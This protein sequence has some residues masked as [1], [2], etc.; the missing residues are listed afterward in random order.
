MRDKL[1]YS[2]GLKEEARLTWERISQGSDCVFVN[3][4]NGKG[5]VAPDKRLPI[6]EQMYNKEDYK[7]QLEA[8]A[9]QKTATKQTN[10]SA[11][12]KTTESLASRINAKP[13]RPL[14]DRTNR[15]STGG[16]ST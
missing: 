12:A 3:L 9:E 14:F 6:F 15:G 5:C 13:W 2:K 10:N 11:P 16:D 1:S 8:K 7:A 4:V